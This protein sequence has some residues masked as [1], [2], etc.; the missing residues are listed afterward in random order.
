MAFQRAGVIIYLAGVMMLVAVPAGALTLTLTGG[1]ANIG[2][3]VEVSV[4]LESGGVAPSS[5][6]LFIQYD[7]AR[8]APYTDFYEFIVQDLEGHS[9]VDNEGNVVTER[10][11]VRPEA[12]IDTAVK[13]VETEVHAAEG[14]L[15]IAIVGKNV[16]EI[17]DGPMLTIAFQILSGAQENEY[18]AVNGIGSAEA[19]VSLAHGTAKSSAAGSDAQAIAVVIQDGQ[20]HV[21]CTPAETPA[22]VTATRG[23]TD[24]V[25][26]SWTAVADA[27]ARYRVYR[28][29]EQDSSTAVPLGEGWQSGVIFQDFTAE[30]PVN[31]GGCS[32]APAYT[33]VR[34]YY[35]VK[36]QNAFGCESGFSTPPAEGYRGNG[37]SGVL[38]A[39]IMPG[40]AGDDWVA[41]CVVGVCAV[42]YRRRGARRNA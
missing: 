35:W 27:N 40:S 8:L 30:V 26:V 13:L 21:G 28:S 7:P 37:K 41:L 32:C 18:I 4:G 10:S 6:V 14:V 1:T 38:K 20:V 19:G 34:Y 33:P 12:S 24:A 3:T 23:Q 9:V 17:P 11:A 5:V 29:T 36:A 22:G 2:D 42:F 31:S 16:N 25:V 39:G 15:A